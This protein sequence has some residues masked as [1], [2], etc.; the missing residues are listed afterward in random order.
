MVAEK[1]PAILT[2]HFFYHAWS[3]ERTLQSGALRITFVEKRSSWVNRLGAG[4]REQGHEVSFAE[5]PD[6]T[7]GA[8]L[9]LLGVG[10]TADLTGQ[11]L[12]AREKAPDT[13]VILILS[14][15]HQGPQDL[16]QASGA[17]GS[18]ARGNGF[19]RAI[20]AIEAL[21]Y[22]QQRLVRR[23]EVKSR[24]HAKSAKFS[25]NGSL[26]DIA[27]GG[28][29]SMLTTNCAN[30]WTWQSTIWRMWRG[31]RINFV[32]TALIRELGVHV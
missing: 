9:V 5:S 20:G 22:A 29:S 31:C 4:L 11:V 14:Q 3:G 26:R 12:R 10:A 7:E 13:K 6:G 32:L 15:K 28:A 19:W 30:T 23:F 1:V 24:L 27:V 25:A 2:V 16:L 17:D 18:I 8:G 21:A